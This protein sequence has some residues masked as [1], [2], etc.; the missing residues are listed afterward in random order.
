MRYL[1]QLV[2]Q[3]VLIVYALKKFGL[4]KALL[5]QKKDS[6]NIIWIFPNSPFGVVAYLA[7]AAVIQDLAL[8]YSCTK[9]LED[10][11]I[12]IGPKIGRHRN[13]NVYYSFT[14]RFN[15][16][17]FESN[18]RYLQA[19]I[20]ALNYQGCTTFPSLHELRFWEDKEYMYSVFKE[21]NIAH[22]KTVNV[23]TDTNLLDNINVVKR[24][25]NFPVLV[26]EHFGNQ[27][28]GLYFVDSECDL[29][30]R[31]LKLK[32]DDVSSVSVQ[33]L[34]RENSDHRVIVVNGTVEQHYER[35]RNEKSGENSQWQTTSTKFGTVLK[36]DTMDEKYLNILEEYAKRLKLSNAAFDVI[37]KD[38]EI[39]V[40][41]VSSSYYTNP[42]PFNEDFI[43]YKEF[44]NKIFS[45]NK[46]KIDIVFD[47]REK[48]IKGLINSQQ[49]L[50]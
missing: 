10:Y 38:E 37:I 22:P 16:N 40:L 45:H 24:N 2:N 7:T 21:K 12:V 5:D 29:K 25:F 15:P 48:W 14:D 28:K 18:S 47:L 17:E 46:L 11:R 31:F 19:L 43:P 3:L 33:Q 8:L 42:R 27:S 9:N 34:I 26:K 36:F 13:K 39:F 32:S 1:K 41:E 20:L 30:A 4:L 6:K 50:R 23:K 44:K 49:G 35:V